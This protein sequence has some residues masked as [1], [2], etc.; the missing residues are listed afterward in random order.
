MLS[1]HLVLAVICGLATCA[2]LPRSALAHA[3]PPSHP[4]ADVSE[5]PAG[6]LK[7]TILDLQKRQR[8]LGSSPKLVAQ[9]LQEAIRAG[10]RARGARESG[11]GRHGAM[12][13]ALGMAW[14]KVA[15]AVLTAVAT[16][17]RALAAA[18]RLSQ[19]RTQVERAEALLT[20]QQARFRRLRS[21]V[22]ARQEGQ[23][24]GEDAKLDSERERVE[25]S[26]K[27]SAKP[28]TKSA[29]KPNGDAKKTDAKGAKP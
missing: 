29:T 13:E 3:S 18:K 14:T 10:T 2:M 15:D 9:P 17:A 22:D 8:R 19:L 24:A 21:E 11:D 23:R 20:E 28:A 16:E 25:K 12:L 26:V 6:P 5:L 7:R 4:A 1:R 27:P